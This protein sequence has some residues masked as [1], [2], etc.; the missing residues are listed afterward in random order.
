M[1]IFDRSKLNF[2]GLHLMY[3]DRCVAKFKYQRRSIPSFK[4]FLARNFSVEEYF[5][6]LEAGESPLSVLQS[7]G[8]IQPFMR[9]VLLDAGLPPTPAGREEYLRRE[10]LLRA[11]RQAAE[12][13]LVPSHNEG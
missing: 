6:R 3:D 2:D 8:Y 1:T 4:S 11:G 9:R 7:K 5:T 12:A 10:A 13:T